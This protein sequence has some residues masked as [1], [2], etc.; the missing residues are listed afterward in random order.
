[1]SEV[2]SAFVFRE[3]FTDFSACFPERVNRSFFHAADDP[4]ELAEDGFDRVQVGAVRRK[5]Q[6]ASSSGGNRFAN[7][8]HLV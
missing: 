1:M 3:E 6:H 5:E 4:L 2:S 8:G 7:S